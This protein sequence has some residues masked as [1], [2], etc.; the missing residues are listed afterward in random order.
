MGKETMLHNLKKEKM[1]RSQQQEKQQQMKQQHPVR[2]SQRLKNKQASKMNDFEAFSMKPNPGQLLQQQKVFVDGTNNSETK[3]LIIIV[4]E[5]QMD[6]DKK[7]DGPEDE[8]DLSAPEY[9]RDI[10]SWYKTVENAEFQQ[11]LIKKEYISTRFQADLNESMRRILMDWLFN[12]HRRF[13]LIPRALY[14]A[15]YILDGY[16]SKVA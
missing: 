14:L 2:R 11:T 10:T 15:I 9:A 4:E 16:L 3:P 12:V 5:A 8:A 13:Q 6:C 7:H 1:Q